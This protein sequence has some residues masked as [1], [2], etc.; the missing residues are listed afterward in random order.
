MY[1]DVIIPLAIPEILSYT[2]ELEEEKDKLTVG[3]LVA[4]LM[5]KKRALS[6]I[7]ISIHL[8]ESSQV[9]KPIL[10][11]IDYDSN[12]C[13]K[14]IDF[15]NWLG[16]YYFHSLGKIALHLLPPSLKL[17]TE[18]VD[19]TDGT[20]EFIFSKVY[21]FRNREYISLT[22]EYHNQTILTELTDSLKRSKAKLK[23]VE[24]FNSDIKAKNSDINSYKAEKK[25]LL[26]RAGATTATLK[27]LVDN[28]VFKSE[29]VAIKECFQ[30]HYLAPLKD[31]ND[32]AGEDDELINRASTLLST[33][34][35]LLIKTASQTLKTAIF[36]NAI[37]EQLANGGEVL[38][39]SPTPLQSRLMYDELQD[40]FAPLTI[41]SDN[42]NSKDKQHSNYNRIL[43]N[44]GALIVIGGRRTVALPFSNIKLV[45]VEDEHE[46]SYK[47]SEYELQYGGRDS[48]IYLAY[49]HNAKCILTS[50]APSIESYYNSMTGK[51]ALLEQKS[52]FIP[53]ITAIERSSIAIKER[54]H[55]SSSSD[56][57]F[58]STL[59]L[60]QIE[61][62]IKRG[63]VSF[64]YQN[65]KGFATVIECK[66]CGEYIKCDNCNVTLT[67]HKT[68]DSLLCKYC[69]S[70]YKRAIECKS[71]GSKNLQMQG[72]GTENV[73]DKISR[74]FP[75]S[76]VIRIDSESVENR[77]KYSDIVDKIRAGEVDIIVGTDLFTKFHNLNN[78]TLIGVINGDNMF[79]FP[80]YFTT[81]RAY[82]TVASLLYRLPKNESSKMVI[83]IS[84]K[85]PIYKY[86]K[87]DD[88]HSFYLKEI[89]DRRKFVYPPFCKIVTFTL[90]SRDTIKLE[91]SA[92][93]L[94][95]EL[96]T[97]FGK[98]CSGVYTPQ[99]DKIRNEYIMQIVVKLEKG[100]DIVRAKDII[101]RVAKKHNRPCKLSITTT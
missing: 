66:E 86:I 64:L 89:E 19:K 54:K 62:R 90:K 56:R 60:N 83:Q 4:I 39:I 57:R 92:I 8:G 22:E 6:A 15:W 84:G 70:H 67:Y 45:I 81:E 58:I 80:E 10:S 20:K 32:H 44:K 53:D 75:L 63:E 47:G 42:Q 68:T 41:L 48:A 40:E 43:H 27:Q 94:S 61:E 26:E 51:Y 59:L 99:V 23:L 50:I 55:I 69:S 33:K 95:N 87:Q 30:D 96:T 3:S 2:V 1:I 25:T 79:A 12:I 21:G 52:S 72:I 5:G 18:G 71:C 98:R 101:R 78:L 73:E 74:Y 31:N 65:R 29:T 93:N 46:N 16:L 77:K 11:V 97:I 24:M 7:V 37:K 38:I 76:R 49:L 34:S 13:D 100:A 91:E 88:Y 14:Q 28:G 36:K 85:H 35:T 9:L 82:Q 17:Q